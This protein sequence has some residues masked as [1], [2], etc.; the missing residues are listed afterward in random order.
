MPTTR[1]YKH[2]TAAAV[3]H[4]GLLIHL[5]CNKDPILLAK[6]AQ[7]CKS[8]N[9]HVQKEL[10]TQK[11]VCQFLR[12]YLFLVESVVNLPMEDREIKSGAMM[13]FFT[14]IRQNK[15]LILK[16][17]RIRII[18]SVSQ[19]KLRELVNVQKWR[20]GARFLA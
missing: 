10:K 7:T 16:T 20:E 2:K 14:F 18:W 11:E 4:N 6:F 5:I 15:D 19:E 13:Y 1:A 3:G 17:E 12:N 9:D 8:N